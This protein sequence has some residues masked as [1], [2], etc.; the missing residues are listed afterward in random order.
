MAASKQGAAASRRSVRNGRVAVIKIGSSTITDAQGRVD[1][2]YLADL[3]HQIARVRKDGWKPIIVSSGSIP[4]G[5]EALGM[6]LGRP[7]EMALVQAAASVGQRAL[8]AA[9]DQVFSPYG[10]IT[11]LVLLTRRDTADRTAYLHARDTLKRL[12]ELDV[13]PIVN[14]ND[15]VSIEQIKF[16]D[17]DTLAALVACI[18]DADRVVLMSDIDGL[19]TSNP[20]QDRD[21]RFLDTV[22]RITPE[23][24]K[25][26]SGAGSVVGSGGMVTKIKAARVLSCAG[27]PMVICHGRMD[28]AVIRS[29]DQRPAGTLF[30]PHGGA[31]EITPRK[32][33]IALGD[34]VKGRIIVDAGAVEALVKGGSSLLCVG[35]D[36]LDGEFESGD[37][38][39]VC[40]AEGFVYARGLTRMSSADF[41][42]DS[43]I[44]IHRDEL[45]V[46]E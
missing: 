46:F 6:P 21:A 7:R 18:V 31:H 42:R 20:A 32:L 36:R 14:E 40:D 23:I 8:S 16:G 22:E 2:A 26:A 34:S 39:D 25:G 3:A 37:V 12:I 15:T 38:V 33:W 44:L 11:S 43:G 41:S 13:V 35:V 4:C 5:L 17:N 29:L 24:L 45:V 10:I 30:V 9:Y 1:R 28:D 27:I 19:Y